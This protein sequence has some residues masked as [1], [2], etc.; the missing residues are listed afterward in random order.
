MRFRADGEE[1][2][3]G[4]A[5]GCLAHAGCV[6]IDRWSC[7]VFSEQGGQLSTTGPAQQVH[8]PQAL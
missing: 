1:F 2:L 4:D 8:L 5:V 3:R 7:H 6:D